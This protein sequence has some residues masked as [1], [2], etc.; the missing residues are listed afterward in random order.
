MKIQELRQLVNSIPREYN[1]Q[2]VYNTIRVENENNFCG[3]DLLHDIDE[4][5]YDVE[6]GGIILRS[7]VD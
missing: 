6:D 5:V 4:F 3:P 1:N 7:V 2:P